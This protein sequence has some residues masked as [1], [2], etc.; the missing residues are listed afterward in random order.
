MNGMTVANRSYENLLRRMLD[1]LQNMALCTQQ[2]REKPIPIRNG[3]IS[4]QAPK[5]EDI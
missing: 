2:D 4:Y 3:Q 1:G 5:K